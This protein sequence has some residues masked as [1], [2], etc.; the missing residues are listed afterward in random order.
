MICSKGGGQG[1][2]YHL[3]FARLRLIKMVL[4]TCLPSLDMSCYLWNQL[5]EVYEEAWADL[6]QEW[7]Q[8]LFALVV[9]L[10]ICDNGYFVMS[11]VTL[12]CFC[13]S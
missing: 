9:T 2:L 4:L 5:F 8:I 10:A 6:I 11:L 7:S 12:F 13:M 1:W 3:T